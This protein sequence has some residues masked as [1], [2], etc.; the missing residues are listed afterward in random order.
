MTST[1][2]ATSS[3]RVVVDLPVLLGNA[4][5]LTRQ[6]VEEVMVAVAVRSLL[7]LG[8][9]GRMGSATNLRNPYD[10]VVRTLL[11]GAGTRDVSTI[12]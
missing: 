11:P 10:R 5:G 7:D 6:V 1:S 3:G 12:L 8:Y 4:C 2:C 9:C